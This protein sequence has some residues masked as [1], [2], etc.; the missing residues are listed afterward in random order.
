M[1]ALPSENNPLSC[2]QEGDMP[3]SKE[4]Q[5][6]FTVTDQQVFGLLVMVENHFVGFTPDA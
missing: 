4:T 5:L 2:K 3:I 1:T 6:V